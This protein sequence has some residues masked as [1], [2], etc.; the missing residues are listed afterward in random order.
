M[1]YQNIHFLSIMRTGD[2]CSKQHRSRDNFYNVNSKLPFFKLR[3]LLGVLNR[4]TANKNQKTI[5]EMFRC[6]LYQSAYLKVEKCY[7]YHFYGSSSIWPQLFSFLFN[8]I[9]SRNYSDFEVEQ[10]ILEHFDTLS[11]EKSN[12]LFSE[13]LNMC[14]LGVT[15]VNQRSKYVE[16]VFVEMTSYPTDIWY[17]MDIK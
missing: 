6:L 14:S 11:T 17:Q 15:I 2:M 10:E 7:A 4:M 8:L 5:W 9:E 13:N 3:C 1:R 16:T 12:I